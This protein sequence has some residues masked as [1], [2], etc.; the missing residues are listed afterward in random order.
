[1]L[2]AAVAVAV[3]TTAAGCGVAP[4]APEDRGDRLQIEV[5]P[6]DQVRAVPA[7]TAG[8]PENLVHDFLKSTVGGGEAAI[9]QARAF[10]TDNAVST[11]RGPAD[12]QNPDL[13]VIHIVRGPVE[14]IGNNNRVPVT[15][16]YQVVG[17]LNPQGMVEELSRPSGGQMTFWVVR[18][19]DDPSALRI[20]E[21]QGA[22]SGLLL[23]DLAL[24]DVY[25]IQ[26]VYFWDRNHEQLIP[27]LRYLPLTL[28]EPQRALR[29]VQWLVQGPST[30]LTG[31]RELPLGTAANSVVMRDGKFVV[32]LSKE[33]TA[34]NGETPEFLLRQLQWS[35]SNGTSSRA[36][37]LQIDGRTQVADGGD[38]FRPFN[39]SWVY[40]DVKP[41]FDIA[42]QKVVA[43]GAAGPAVLGS[44]DNREVYRAAINREGTVLA[45]VKL[46]GNGQR[47][48]QIVRADGPTVPVD[49]SS[50]DM[51][52][53]SFVPG[54]DPYLVVPAGGHLWLVSTE[55]GAVRDITPARVD[56]VTAAVVAPD[57]RRIVFVAGGQVYVSSLVVDGDSLT[58]G[59]NPRAILTDRVVATGVAWADETWL[60]VGGA[61]PGGAPAMWKV[62]ADGVV[63]KDESGDLRGLAVTDVVA[64]TRWPTAQYTEVII[65]TAGGPYLFSSNPT[66]TG[67]QAP[68]FGG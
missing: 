37:E 31:A 57:G 49:L 17:Q 22:P 36:V 52:R 6:G 64:G 15:V 39:Q 26:P 34:P 11:W 25:R 55:T 24:T 19:P 68:F 65:Y 66:Q 58:V 20:D 48:L 54:A 9:T 2:A 60:Y 61:A 5:Q 7:P 67:Q 28:S 46:R 32:D 63:T 27:D 21:I 56:D 18:A 23:S 12:P 43:A 14:G 59:S 51:G 38:A 62:S 16:D 35:L 47:Y 40:R 30:W 42:E 33:A 44:P 1:L 41:R 4:S 10:L 13:T 3:V 8:N 45:L 29:L 53:P 50:F